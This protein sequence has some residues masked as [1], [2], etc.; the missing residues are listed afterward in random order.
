MLI[1]HVSYQSISFCVIFLF[2]LV[3]LHIDIRE[4]I[5]VLG[6]LC[7]YTNISNLRQLDL[8]IDSFI[9]RDM[10]K[11]YSNAVFPLW[12]FV[13]T[14]SCEHM[15]LMIISDSCLSLE[16]LVPKYNRYWHCLIKHCIWFEFS[17]SYNSIKLLLSIFS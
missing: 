3:H 15:I 5:V 9:K 14:F 17:K 10:V 13:E 7:S 6:N 16:N 12:L 2:M 11:F 8:T 1:L 4:C